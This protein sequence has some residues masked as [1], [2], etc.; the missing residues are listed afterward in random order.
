MKNGYII[1]GRVVEK[2]DE[3]IVL[4]FA[5]GRVTIYNR[6]VDDVVLEPG[7]EENLRIVKEIR[8]NPKENRS[9]LIRDIELPATLS[10][11][12]AIHTDPRDPVNQGQD[13]AMPFNDGTGVVVEIPQ[14]PD[15]PAETELPSAGVALVIPESWSMVVRQT[16]QP[17]I[18]LICR[19]MNRTNLLLRQTTRLRT[20]PAWI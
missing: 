16:L 2:D 9:Y 6:F 4:G 20:I 11:I 13:P 8:Q 17:W 15:L 14:N 12:M 5:N 19:W 10:E 1:Q 3:K 7:E 18:T